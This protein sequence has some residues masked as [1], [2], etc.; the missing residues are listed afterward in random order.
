MQDLF[1]QII[2]KSPE[3]V[4][5][6]EKS[7]P[8]DRAEAL[9]AEGI[10]AH[11]QSAIRD[12]LYPLG[13]GLPTEAALCAAHNASRYAVRQA[14]G[15]LTKLGLIERRQGSGS[16]VRATEPRVSYAQ[17]MGSLDELLQYAKDTALTVERVRLESIGARTAQMIGSAANKRWLHVSGLRHS[18]GGRADPIAWTDVY[19]NPRF[20][21]VTGRLDNKN[22][23]IYRLIEEMFGE[24]VHQV[25]QTIT[26]A[27]VPGRIA[28]RLQMP[29]RQAGLRVVRRYLGGDRAVLAVA[30]NLHPA[31]RFHYSMVLTR[32]VGR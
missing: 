14:L 7:Q 23:P 25:E 4:K 28:A 27:L 11:L 21:N 22:V 16:I 18:M 31:D 24:T 6:S 1:E 5:M 20:R 15:S 8:R 10:A 32:N 13:A 19:I 29:Q 3:T 9:R 26:A 17:S 30:V 2:R 12:G